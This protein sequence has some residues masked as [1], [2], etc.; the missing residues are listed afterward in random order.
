M[1]STLFSAKNGIYKD[2]TH[3]HTQSG[4]ENSLFQFCLLSEKLNWSVNYAS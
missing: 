3:T 4:A 1:Y 2:K